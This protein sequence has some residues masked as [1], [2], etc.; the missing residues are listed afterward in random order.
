MTIEDIKNDLPD[1]AY[2]IK[3]NLSNI[4]SEE[5]CSGLSQKQMAIVTV[6]AAMSTPS[7]KLITAALNFAK[8]LL[9]KKELDGAK[10]AHV[11]MSMTNVYYRFLHVVDNKEYKRMPPKLEMKAEA[12]PGISKIDFHLA[13]IG[14][15]SINFCKACIDYHELAARRMGVNAEGIQSVVRIAAV[16][17]ATG[18]LLKF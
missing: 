17:N 18:Q 6:A 15:S 1:Y 7:Q 4:F 14:V 10:T 12:S 3:N 2:D 11:I 16:I 8:P 9:S 5:G 13:S